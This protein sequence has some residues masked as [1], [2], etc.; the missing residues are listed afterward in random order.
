MSDQNQPDEKRSKLRE[1]YGE[2]IARIED[3]GGSFCPFH[4]CDESD[5]KSRHTTHGTEEID[6]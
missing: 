5:C 4:L 1:W 3:K 6:R 2:S